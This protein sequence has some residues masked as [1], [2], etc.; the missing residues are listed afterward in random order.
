M[1]DKLCLRCDWSG[2]IDDQACPRCGAEL[3]S[4]GRGTPETADDRR[5][6]SVREEPLRRSWGGAVAVV[7]IVAFAIGAVVFV[8]RH[9]P[10]T[11][12]PVPISTGRHGFLLSASREGDGARLWIWN[13][14]EN[15]AVPGPLLDDLPEELVNGYA[16]HGGWIGLTTLRTS[17]VR[18]ASV[19]RFLGTGDQP[20]RVATGDLIAWSPGSSVVSV[21]RSRRVGEC[22][23]LSIST[24]FVTIRRSVDRSD[25]V[26]CGEP[27]AFARDRNLRYLTV[28]RGEVPTTFRVGAGY[29]PI[30]DGYRLLSV[31][32]DGDLLVQRPGG[33][34]ELA[35]LSSIGS[36]IWER[37]RPI[38]GPRRALDPIRVLGWSVDGTHAFVFGRYDSVQG[39]FRVP[40]GP[41]PRP[42][43]PTRLLVTNA[44]DVQAAPTADDEVYLLTDG[45][46]SVVHGDRVT[47]V[48]TPPGM[49]APLGP[50]L[51]LATL[52]YSS[53]E[54]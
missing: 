32:V 47:P 14:D 11:A 41:T 53:T 20:V 49:P 36:T 43:N 54:G 34:L 42:R 12:S 37:P 45:A 39:I 48:T 27:V 5:T 29:A 17:G 38:G 13:L 40:V 19:L 10:T 23:R 4:S 21:L 8:Q 51:W 15:T 28:Q 18:T 2:D 16:V 46:V 52:P 22:A 50:I 30:L 6:P 7:L 26:L 31:S 24:W 3:F 33:V 44:V 35:Y 1:T 9:T 25:G